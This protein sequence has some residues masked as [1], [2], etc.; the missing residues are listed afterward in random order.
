MSSRTGF[1]LA[2]ALL[3][4]AA[5]L[6]LWH[7]SS[8]PPG[9]HN[10]EITDIRITEAIRQ[11]NIA[12]FYNLEPLGAQG[13]RE[14][15][16]HMLLFATTSLT[17][18]G[19]MGYRALSVLANLL[20]LALVY[21]LALRLYGPLAGVA[22][23]ALLVVGFWPTLLARSIGRETLVPLLVAAALL[24]LARALPVYYQPSPREPGTTPF[25]ALGLLL[26]LGFYLHPVHFLLALGCMIFIAYM[27]IS[28]QPLSSR[29][30]SYIG[31]AIL[32]MVI[33][34]MPYLLSSVRLPEL[35]GAGRVFGDS[36]IDT[37]APLTALGGLFFSG[38]TNPIHNL[39]GRPLLDLISGLIVLVGLLAALRRWHRP[40]F[41]LTLVA[42]ITLS[43]AALLAAHSPDFNA[44]AGLLPLL[45]VLFGLGTTTLFHSL[46][47]RVRPLL[48]VGL[49]GLLVFNLV[50]MGRDLFQHWPARPD[51]YE[52]YQG[53]VGQLAAHIDH[54]A[55][56]IPTLV[57][58]PSMTSLNSRPQLNEAQILLL[59]AHSHK[60]LIRYAD[61]GSALV[62]A[63][64][65]ESEQVILPLPDMLDN[66][67]LYLRS[68]LLRGEV[69]T[70]PDLPPDGVIRLEIAQEL[71]DTI[72]RFTTTAPVTYAPEAP[73][74]SAATLPPVT[75]G[76]NLTFL[77]YEPGPEQTYRPGDILT[78]ITYWRV[79]GPP[80]PD[81]RLFTHILSDP[82]AIIS[83]TDTLSVLPGY[84][85]PRDIFIQVTFVSLPES[86]PEGEY[87]V[88]IGVYQQSDSSRLP[89]LVEGQE[90]GTR[91]FLT[92]YRV[93]VAL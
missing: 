26:G 32:V 58:L 52:T 8:L 20:T 73:G 2:A 54:S 13:G 77:G 23:L 53:R 1:T 28:P 18:G 39:P 35:D 82:A 59:M 24:A 29:T 69:V 38:D 7:L 62:V 41:A 44:F 79:D 78:V 4:L 9:L 25:A 49:V 14:G 85:Q 50:W 87:T 88:S 15:L 16:Y 45:A 81:I 86:T 22:A 61:C 48:G 10:E 42:L 6:R 65:G 70:Q 34:A 3:L 67:H 91:L 47:P 68:W 89:V 21:A 5:G 80:P 33:V 92:N 84:L 56:D 43:P 76:G 74:G 75:F 72:G 90:R 11:G 19:L 36:R 40:R 51:V 30:L 17:G 60:N 66:L 83:Q 37:A 57:C 93:R 55:A 12:V 64:G 31:F 71:A 27:V 63:K 46:Q